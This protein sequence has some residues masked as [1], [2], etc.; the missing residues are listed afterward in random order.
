MLTVGIYGP[1]DRILDD[2]SSSFMSH[3]HNVTFM[4]D[5]KIIG[6]IELER[7]TRLKHDNNLDEYIE[8]IIDC[9]WDKKEKMR[10][11][12]ANSFVSK[13]FIS[14]KG[15]LKIFEPENIDIAEICIKTT[16]E[17]TCDG[18]VV[19]SEFYIIV[20][21]FAHIATVLPFFG[22]FK[23]NSMLFHLDGGAYDSNHSLWI[24]KNGHI[25]LID[26]GW[27]TLKKPLNIFND[28]LIA[29]WILEMDLS[30]HLSIPGKLMGFASWGVP[31][32]K[33]YKWLED[34]DWFMNYDGSKD[35]FE[36]VLSDLTGESSTTISLQNQTCKNIA[37]CFQKYFTDSI[38]KYLEAKH[39]EFDCDYLYYSGG[40]SLNIITNTRIENELG[41]KSIYIPPAPSDCG[42]SLG[43]ASY[44]EWKEKGEIEYHSPFLNNIGIGD[45]KGDFDKDQLVS[46]IVSGKVSLL[47]FGNGEFG[48]RALGHRSIVG[49][50]DSIK[51]R[52][53]ISENVKKR[54]WYRPVAPMILESVALEALI[55]YKK[56]SNLSE[57][58]LGCW[59]VKDNWIEKLKGVIHSDGTVRAQV[60]KKGVGYNLG[61]YDLLETLWNDYEL[62]GIINT[63]LNVKGEPIVHK[64]SDASGLGFL[65]FNL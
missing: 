23:E 5:G 1:K 28:N 26:Y 13:G 59:K 25:N 52:K 17:F 39:N 12:L 62:A 51:L 3:D 49:R 4:R 64:Y 40:A 9:V 30:E 2:G 32:K 8:N 61:V 33:L 58:M 14:K 56:D 34:N 19:D 20:H 55:D 42:L 57:F 43:A 31:D 11:I 18:V 44:I 50:T 47:L 54:E 10:F 15:S 46:N 41:F 65:C 36:K 22:K 27:E 16:G 48:P 21:E 60:V 37:S 35:E 63:S 53:Q 6:A 7:Y 38:I 45:Y 24:Y 29:A